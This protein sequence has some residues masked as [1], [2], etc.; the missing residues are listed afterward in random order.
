MDI[1]L[2]RLL[3]KLERERSLSSG[4]WVRLI[5]GRD[6]ELAR[7]AAE[8]ADAVRRRIYGNRVYIRGLIEISSY[9]KNGCLYCGINRDNKNAVRYRL[10]KS[11]ILACCVKGYEL[12]FRTFVLQGGE[13]P[14]FTDDLVCSIVGEI[15]AMFPDCAV[16]LSL[17][18][19]SGQTYRRYFESGADRYLL[20]H[21]TAD[22][23]HYKSLHPPDMS[24][25]N[26]K[27]CLFDLKKI[28][29]Q[30]GSGFMVGSP[31]QTAANL[32][33]DMLF[34][35]ELEPHMVGI[36]PFV[37]HK[38]TVFADEPSGSVELTLFLI[39]CIRLMLPCALIP[40]TPALGT[41]DGCGREKGICAGAN[42]VMPNLSPPDARDK[43]MLYDNKLSSGGESA[44][45]LRQLSEN[46]NKIGYE[47]EISR[48]D[49]RKGMNC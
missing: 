33:D 10:E 7:L 45:G 47:I 46:L 29:F 36:G 42:V 13:D 21:E 31:H 25:E 23:E 18:E 15:K 41:L 35:N 34:L 37:H 2:Y 39:S 26:R 28:G 43:Y 12:G 32:A 49:F 17:G 19:K 3:E 9:C 8:K 40:A 22:E 4:E 6:G 5:E 24:L 27:R 30:A 48:G 38:D 14:Y 44:E 11:D 1:T 16:T 20:R